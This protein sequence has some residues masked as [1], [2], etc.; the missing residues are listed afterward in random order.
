MMD[1]GPTTP[2]GRGRLAGSSAVAAKADD[3]EDVFGYPRSLVASRDGAHLPLSS[4]RGGLSR[5]WGAGILMR[6]DED[7]AAFGLAIDDVRAGYA[8]LLECIRV[9]GS[10]D[11]LSRRFPWPTGTPAAPQSTRYAAM[12][13]EGQ[14][15]DDVL[16]GH[17]RT[18]ID[19][20]GPTGCPEHLFF[21]S[22]PALERLASDGRCTLM[23][24][25]AITIR[26][27]PGG[28]EVVAPSGAVSARRVLIAAGPIGTPSILQRS[29][30]VPRILEAEDSAVFYAAF[31]NRNPRH[32]DESEYTAAQ[33]MAYSSTGGETDFQMSLYESNPADYAERLSSLVPWVR[34]GVVPPSALQWLNPAIGFL[35]PAVSGRLR[36]ETGPTDRTWVTRFPS[37]QSRQAASS[38]IRRI[39]RLVR[40]LGLQAI[41]WAMLVP[42]PGSGYHTGAALPVGGVHVDWD[43]HLRTHPAVLVVDASSL[44]RIWAGSHTFT[45][46]AN[47]WRIAAG[48]AA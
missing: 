30:L 17:P 1:F 46:M 41:P 4:A 11:A 16:L 32:G 36:I 22:G 38:V 42:P 3:L 2:F 24:G 8:A 12:L 9:A 28:V 45:A 19:L 39:K 14:S 23:T 37:P 33:A 44:P 6:S 27:V 26:V 5:V 43:G 35:D 48:A 47:A 29:S 10:Q 25:P 31:L 18:A 7:L 21:S 15:S 40:P 13:A 20:L 34:Q